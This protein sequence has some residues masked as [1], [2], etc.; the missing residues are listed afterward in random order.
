MGKISPGGGSNEQPYYLTL[1][2]VSIQTLLHL[3][4]H[5]ID[6]KKIEFKWMH[7]NAQMVA[8]VKFR[9]KPIR[10]EWGAMPCAPRLRVAV[11]AIGTD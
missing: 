5:S 7:G 1:L 6:L 8:W 2:A 4:D 3:L 10:S 9:T 11:E